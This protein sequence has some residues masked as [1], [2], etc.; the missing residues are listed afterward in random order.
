MKF[1][2]I[3]FLTPYKVQPLCIKYQMNLIPK[4]YNSY[5]YNNESIWFYFFQLFSMPPSFV[6]LSILPLISV[7]YDAKSDISQ[8]PKISQLIIA[9]FL[10]IKT[11]NKN[12]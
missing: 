12:C 4:G 10:G 7:E 6:N 11:I 3:P 9:N 5:I 1:D 8:F 2:K